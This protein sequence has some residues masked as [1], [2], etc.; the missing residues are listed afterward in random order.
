MTQLGE[1]EIRLLWALASIYFTLRV[2]SMFY[3]IRAG[4]YS[5]RMYDMRLKE[6]KDRKEK[7]KEV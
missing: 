3:Q 6:M 7:E 5:K 1:E 2:T 4:V